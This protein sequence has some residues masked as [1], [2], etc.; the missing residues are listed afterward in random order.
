MSYSIEVVT[1]QKDFDEIL[2]MLYVAF[3]EPNNA[4]RRWFMPVHTT[5]QAAIEASKQRT[6]KHWIQN[7]DLYWIKATDAETGKIIG[8]AEWDIRRQ[9]DNPG[10]P[11]KPIEAGWH[12]PGSEEKAFAGRLLTSLKGFMKERMTRPHIELEQLVVHPNHR[13]KGVGA[14][15]VHWGNKKADEL[16]LESCVESVPFPVPFYEKL[17]YGNMDQLNPDVAVE[18]PSE[19]W[20]EFEAHDLR[21][22]IMWRPVGHDY[23][24]AAD[25][26]PWL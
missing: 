3:G 21:V 9:I 6:L 19:K 16:G 20:K 17:G 7:D 24:P 4:L 26:A 11:Q 1:N 13:E 8:A 5:E 22:F 2:P 25:K 15:L 10:G 18:N 23:R 12:L 14:L